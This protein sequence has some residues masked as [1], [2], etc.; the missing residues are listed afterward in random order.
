MSV[1]GRPGGDGKQGE[2]PKIFVIG[3]LITDI[4]LWGSCVRL[5]LRLQLRLRLSK[6]KQE[7]KGIV[8]AKSKEKK[9][10]FVYY[11]VADYWICHVFC[12]DPKLF[13]QLPQSPW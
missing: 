7:K 11:I 5:R 2:I 9:H 3:R 4:V 12:V 1:R 8:Q 6:Q 13:R 10:C